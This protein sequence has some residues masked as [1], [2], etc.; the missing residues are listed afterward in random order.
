MTTPTI[1][2]RPACHRDRA[3]IVAITNAAYVVE[4]NFVHGERTDNK[5]IDSCFEQGS[6]FV[7]Y[8]NDDDSD[9]VGSVFWQIKGKRGYFGLLAVTPVAQGLGIS[10]NL[11]TAVEQHCRAQQCSFVDISVLSVR[12]ELFGFY[13]HLGYA[14]FDTMAFDVPEKQ[15]VPFHL[16][17]MTKA[18]RDDALL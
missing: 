3:S 8:R 2:I 9:V 14:S 13:R 18:L 11:V 1:T 10:K 7:A 16:I 15:K 4:N 17:R 5:H 12:T 6:F